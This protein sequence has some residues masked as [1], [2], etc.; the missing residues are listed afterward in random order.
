MILDTFHDERNGYRFATNP[1]GAKWDAQ[2]VNEGR[3]INSNWDGI[4]SVKTQV[5]ATGWYAEMA[6]PFRTLRFSDAD[7]QTWGIN[8]LRRVRRH[9][10]DSLWAP[11]PRIYRID[12]VSMAGTLEGMRGIRPGS[13]LRLKPY[14]LSS[15]HAVGT[16]RVDGDVP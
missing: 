4:W 14:G 13:D 15:A 12:R 2:M 8:F 1:L 9:N 6:I 11:L 10:E 3:D 16:G 5:G 7:V